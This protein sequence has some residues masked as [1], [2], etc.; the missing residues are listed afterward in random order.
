MFGPRITVSSSHIDMGIIIVVLE[1]KG[2]LW[3]HWYERWF[4]NPLRGGEWTCDDERTPLTRKRM[5]NLEDARRRLL[6]K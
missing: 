2:W 5:R 6:K 1:V 4:S 3:G